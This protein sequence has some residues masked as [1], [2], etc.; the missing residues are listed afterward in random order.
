MS[1]YRDP[2]CHSKKRKL[3]IML[4]LPIEIELDMLGLPPTHSYQIEGQEFFS[5][6]GDSSSAVVISE[7]SQADLYRDVPMSS[8]QLEGQ[9]EQGCQVFY[10]EP[11]THYEQVSLS[12]Y[13]QSTVVQHF[14]PDILS[15]EEGFET[16]QLQTP[17]VENKRTGN[18]L[19]S[20][21]DGLAYVIN[22][23]GAILSLGKLVNYSWE[24]MVQR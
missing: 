10:T 5:Q 22:G 8:S 7:V 19:D 15:L 2:M 24:G 14:C 21:N 13:E 20:L 23:M 6:I 18:L 12:N 11:Q 9:L 16:I 4:K 1:T 17:S 3:L